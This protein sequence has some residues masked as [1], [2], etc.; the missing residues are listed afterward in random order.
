VMSELPGRT[1]AGIV[2]PMGL[3]GL[4]G[5]GSVNLGT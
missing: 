5:R 3:T 2:P 1:E 4:S